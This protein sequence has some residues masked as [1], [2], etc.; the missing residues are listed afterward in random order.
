M[1]I[2]VISVCHIDASVLFG[3]GSTYSYVSYHFA[4]YLDI[5]HESVDIPI[6]MY[7]LIGDSVTVDRAYHYCLGTIED[8]EIR[9]IFYY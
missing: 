8:C 9:L 6:Y 4:S 5:S 7:T 2:G 1:I 3:T